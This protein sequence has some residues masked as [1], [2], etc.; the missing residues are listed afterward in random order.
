[1]T[2]K[3]K[4]SFDN[5][6]LRSL[7]WKA[8]RLLDYAAEQR[9]DAI[10]F[11]DLDVFESRGDAALAELKARADDLGLAIYAGTL[12]VCPSSVIFKP[13]LGTAGEQLRETIRVARALGSP[14]ARVVLGNW[15]DRL[16]PGG[17]RARI[18]D[19]VKVL[20]ACRSQALDAGLKIAVENHAGDMRATELLDLLDAAGADFTG[21]TM[22]AGNAA[23]ALEDPRQNLELLGPRAL[24]TGIRDSTVWETPDGATMQWMAMGEGSVDWSDYFRRYAELCPDVPVFLETISGRQFPLSFKPEDLRAAYP[25]LRPE[26]FAQYRRFMRRGKPQPPITPPD[27]ALDP[28]FQLAELEKSL[29]HCRDVL[30]LGRKR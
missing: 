17:I 1:V 7:G 23:W 14:V 26:E 15:K 2:P 21:A 5:Y 9:L 28:Q 16:S 13:E 30:G 8:A 6:A 19:T 25:E 27:L 10:F 29:R 11:S 12:S 22:D 20:R 3:L 4:L 18:A 24:C